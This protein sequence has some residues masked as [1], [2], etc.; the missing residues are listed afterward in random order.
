[1]GEGCVTRPGSRIRDCSARQRVRV[2]LQQDG[3]SGSGGQIRA[4][5]RF[6]NGSGGTD[7]LASAL[8]VSED[9]IGRSALVNGEI[10]VTAG[11]R[12]LSSN[13]FINQLGINSFVASEMIFCP[14]TP[15]PDVVRSPFGL[16]T[17]PVTGRRAG[18]NGVDL[19]NPLGGGVFAPLSGI[20]TSI[21]SHPRGGSTIVL[22]SNNNIRF[23]FGHTS[24]DTG[25]RRG[26]RVDRGQRI[27]TSDGTGRISGP[28]L[29]FTV[30]LP[31]QGGKSDPLDLLDGACFQ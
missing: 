30:T 13:N 17:H 9:V 25:I 20:I 23:G 4:V 16:R 14:V 26:V 21:F 8:G 31:G 11:R 24:A 22:V 10:V 3:F 19:R 29:H 27:G 18:H 1:M 28:H 2:A 15:T 6:A 7:S 5:F 12:R